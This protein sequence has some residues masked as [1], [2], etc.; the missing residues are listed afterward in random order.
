MDNVKDDSYYAE[1]IID[2]IKTIQKYLG[3]NMSEM[4]KSR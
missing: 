2:N 4:K 3:N 1:L